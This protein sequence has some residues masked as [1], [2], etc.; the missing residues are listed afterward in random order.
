M[1]NGVRLLKQILLINPN[2]S[3]STTAMMVEIAQACVPSDIT[4]MGTTASGNPPMIVTAKELLAAADEVV[5][6]GVRAAAGMSGII[7]S[8]FGD[9]GL[10]RLRQEIPIPAVGICEAAMIAAAD[11][12]RRFGVATTTPDLAASIAENAREL[13]LAHLFTGTRVTAGDPVVLT[14]D[15][16]RLGIALTRA[17]EE[18]FELDQAE[19]VI[20]GGGPL[21][22][23][24]TDLARLFRRPIIAPIP[25]A[26]RRLLATM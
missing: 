25:A 8:A 18:C 10:T 26:A 19:A 24:A 15:A 21:A 11:G 3:R 23:A 14:N 5:E 13:G 1:G 12:Q 9:P 4:V 16:A 22:Q 7:V 6:M 20:I 2:S 17:V